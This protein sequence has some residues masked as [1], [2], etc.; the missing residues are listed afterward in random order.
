MSELKHRNI[1]LPKNRF[2]NRTLGAVTCR[3]DQGVIIADANETD[4]LTVWF[5]LEDV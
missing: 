5:Y 1:L 3:Q 2:G 4:M